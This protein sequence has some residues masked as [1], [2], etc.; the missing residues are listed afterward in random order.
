M[1]YLYIRV[2]NLRAVTNLC[3][4][5]KIS[6]QKVTCVLVFGL[7]ALVGSS[8]MASDEKG[9]YVLKTS[10]DKPYA[11]TDGIGFYDLVGA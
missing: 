10:T 11:K 4:R 8:L 3:D 2:L 1:S 5:I 6:I 7:C 9:V